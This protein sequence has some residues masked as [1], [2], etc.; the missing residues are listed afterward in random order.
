MFEEAMALP[1]A[2]LRTVV[3]QRGDALI[4]P[5]AP[6]GSALQTCT[7]AQHSGGDVLV[8]VWHLRSNLS[9]RGDRRG[10]EK[11]V[12]WTD[13]AVA[14]VAGTGG[15][16]ATVA[17]AAAFPLPLAELGRSCGRQGERQCRPSF[18]DR[19]L[20]DTAAGI[21]RVVHVRLTLGP[22]LATYPG[23][24]SASDEFQCLLSVAQSRESKP[25]NSLEPTQTATDNSNLSSCPR[26]DFLR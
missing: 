22:S 6:I 4:L 2:H 26:L 25:G 3:T 17:G 20:V 10:D 1:S 19:N 21:T 9:R 8:A 15:P 23:P 24:S 11:S 14:L 5:L 16:A 7:V 18:S 12:S 13:A